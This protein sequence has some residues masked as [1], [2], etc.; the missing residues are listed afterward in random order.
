MKKVLTIAAV[1]VMILALSLSAFA[2][3]LSYSVSYGDQTVSV[4][5]GSVTISSADKNVI[6]A[7][8]DA[9][10]DTIEQ[11]G[12]AADAKVVVLDFVPSADVTFPAVVTFAVDD[13]N[14]L[15]AILH[16]NGTAWETISFTKNADGTVSATFNS[17]S[18]VALVYGAAAA[19]AGPA[20]TPAGPQRSPQTGY[21]TVLWIVLAA[22]MVSLAG[23]CFVSA[24]K[25]TQE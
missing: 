17:L 10:L 3:E 15:S 14:A 8:E 25:K 6:T 9:L 21:N 24:R 19:P 22:A 2:A 7:N 23:Y 13:V 16:W 5:G 1:L 12:I 18:P 11:A 20:T 4:N